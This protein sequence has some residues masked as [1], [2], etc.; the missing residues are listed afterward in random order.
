VN[1]PF[2]IARRYF[3]SKRKKNF[4][5]IISGLSMLGVAFATA[6]LVVVL[7]VFNGLEDLLR[8]LYT[9]FD[10]Q[11]KIESVE[12]K[13]FEFTDSLKNKITTLDGVEILTEVIED[14]VYVR[15][16][17][18]D[19]VTPEELTETEEHFLMPKGT[20]EMVVTMKGVSDNFID[21]H[22]LDEH[23]VGG[24]PK[25]RLNNMHAAIIGK[26]IRNTLSISVENDF[27]PIQFF[28]VKNLKS[29]TF[30]P[31]AM[32]SQQFALPSAVF[33]IEKNYDENYVFVPLELA[34][35]LMNYG[36]RRT[37]LEVKL[38]DGASLE[39]VQSRLMAALGSSFNVLTNDEQHSDLYRILK[40]EKL[41]VGLALTLLIAIA[42]INI[43]FSLMMLVIDKKK[44]ISILASLG[45][46]PALIR[47]IFISEAFVISTLGAAVG[48]A[49]GALL[50]WLQDSAGL[51]GMG[52]ETA[53]VMDYP[54]KMVGT[55]FLLV[56]GVIIL[57]T[58]LIA[59]FPARAAAKGIE[60]RAL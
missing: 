59:W 5:N 1:L 16:Q 25:L 11:L 55:D 47:K 14:Y 48:L 50:C 31:A 45:A 17:Q 40:L 43:F 7:S 23:I 33:A 42:A 6:A 35:E 57:I 10:P 54:V 51:V 8:S 12:G 37:A 2:F 60:V 38:K 26:G 24:D 13:S 39:G 22:R 19:I 30:N 49:F 53:V 20:A 52:M 28:Y 41:F 3:L 58:W 21:Q 18:P 34:K 29:N 46:T 36:N 4:I 44:D 15:Y 32:Y 9:A 27:V 56:A